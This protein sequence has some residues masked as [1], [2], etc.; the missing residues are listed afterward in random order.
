MGKAH[1]PKMH[2]THSIYPTQTVMLI[3]QCIKVVQ[4][5]SLKLSVIFIARVKRQPSRCSNS[6]TKIT[7]AQNY[8][9]ILD[10]KP[11]ILTCSLTGTPDNLKNNHLQTPQDH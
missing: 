5:G 8:R 1:I 7:G 3:R 6:H 2:P 11:S 10:M 9:D 4:L